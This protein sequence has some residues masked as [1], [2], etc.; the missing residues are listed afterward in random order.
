MTRDTDIAAFLARHGY[1][2]AQVSPLAQDASFRRYLRIGGGAVLMDA[3]PPEDVRPFL[4]LA[5]HLACIGLS[6]PRIIGADPEAGLLLEEDLGD[7]L[8]SAV[9]SPANEEALFDAAVDTLVAMQRAPPPSD[10]PPWNAALM[11][12]TALGTLFDWW[13]PAVF[14]APAPAKARAEVA[15]ALGVMLSPLASG[16]W[17]FVHRDFFAGNLLWL[18]ERTG[19]RRVG[20]IDFQG[21]ALGHPAYD[22]VSLMQ[23][24][25]RDIHPCLAERALARY[26][27]A[28][29]EFDPVTFRTA[30]DACAAQRHLRVACQWVRLAR[31]DGRPRYLEFGPRTWALLDRALRQP[32]AA[33]LADAL[34][35]WVPQAVRGN[36]PGLAK[37]FPLPLREGETQVQTTSMT[38]RPRTAMVLAA[39]LATR[40]RPLTDETAKPLLVL[41]GQTLLDHALDRLR[42]V[43]VEAV[44]VNALWQ[45]EKV[46]AHLAARTAPPRTVVRLETTLLD[47]GGGVR[48]ALD[49]LGPDPFYVINGDAV[50]LDGPTPALTR[51]AAAWTDDV[52]AVLLLH[53]TFQVHGEVG[54]GDFALDPWGV[55]RRRKEREIVPYMYAGVQLMH[56]RLLDGTPEAAFSTNIVWNRALEAGRL[57][58]VV[59]DGIW[60][61][62][63]IPR[64]LA[65]AEEILQARLTGDA[66]WPWR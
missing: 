48:N 57:R 2:D 49:I 42:D 26:L 44:A 8:F 43:G 7:D 51:L 17:C 50:W 20:V 5:A 64:D 65:E 40:M 66:R 39:G 22:L 10:L 61:H 31:R 29:P 59:H 6:A 16:P 54:A 13:W 30:Y 21:A 53:R 34:D 32:V 47:T 62:L 28:R 24:A 9:L 15:G 3:P 38:I 35:R 33:P 55:P 12:E 23:D 18:P 19:V 63:S 37:T 46:A 11:A 14:G 45:A 41:G 25:R 4:R 58:A 36:P 56:P 60:F 1:G 27:A 52:D